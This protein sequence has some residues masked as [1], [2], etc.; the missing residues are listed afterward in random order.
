MADPDPPP[1]PAPEPDPADAALA[2]AIAAYEAARAAGPIDLDAFCAEHPEL[3]DRLRPALEMFDALE[4][5]GDQPPAEPPPQRIGPYTLGPEL[6]RG[7]FAPVYRARDRRLDRPVAIKLM[8]PGA[9]PDARRRFLREARALAAL[10]HP[11]IV[12]IHDVGEVGPTLYLVMGLM[13][14]T[15]A[16]R[17]PADPRDAVR[18]VLEAAEGLAAAHARGILHRDVKPANLLIGADGRIRVA[19]FG[20]ARFTDDPHLTRTGAA[21]GTP[22]FAAPEQYQNQPATPATDV[23]GLAATLHW[24]IYGVPPGPVVPARPLPPGLTEALTRGLAARPADRPGTMLEFAGLLRRALEEL[25]EAAALDTD[26]GDPAPLPPLRLALAAAVGALAAAPIA[27]A[28]CALLLGDPRTVWADGGHFTRALFALAPLAGASIPVTRALHRSGRRPLIAPLV[29]P[30]LLVIVGAV[31]AGLGALAI[32]SAVQSGVV[33]PER[34]L[35]MLVHALPIA[36]IPEALGLAL[37]GA[38][39]LA[40]VAALGHA[41]PAHSSEGRPLAALLLAAAL[42]ALDPITASA[43]PAA[44]LILGAAGLTRADRRG[45]TAL[46][47]TAWV[48]A[49]A[50]WATAGRRAAETATLAGLG[51]TLRDDPVAAA[52]DLGALLEADAGWS[53][54]T[55]TAAAAALAVSRARHRPWRRPTTAGQR[56]AA[57]IIAASVVAALVFSAT[58]LAWI[59]AELFPSLVGG[60]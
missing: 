9:D 53:V 19:D 41:R 1:A 37:A 6:G 7:G 57:S 55:W 51:A 23:Y 47:L 31:G 25:E 10:D 16:E 29:G 35:P 43:W 12:P 2:E 45:A 30:T 24:L 40:L 58:A 46:R 44:A 28:T 17:R 33:P 18:R 26:G 59:E 5:L 39:A 60:P 20:L 34:V 4:G 14:G 54:L 21:L 42:A 11:H 49:V 50:A 27:A 32:R 48:A 8:R 22:G 15:L 38:L 3:A 13:Q 52:R 36:L 56:A